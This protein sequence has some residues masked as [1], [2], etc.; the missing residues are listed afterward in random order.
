MVFAVEILAE[1]LSHG[2]SSGFLEYLVGTKNDFIVSN[3]REISGFR[4]EGARAQV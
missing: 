3:F 1:H 4:K 2:A